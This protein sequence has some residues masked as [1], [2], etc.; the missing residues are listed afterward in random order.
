[1][2]L[3]IK[4]RT[5]IKLL[6]IG[7]GPEYQKINDLVFSNGLSEYIILTGKISHQEILSYYSIIDVFIYPRRKIRLTDLVTPLKPLEA[8][9]ME[10]IVIG[11]DVGG[12]KEL[13]LH[14]T[15][16]L[17]FEAGDIEDLMNKVLSVL[18][19]KK[20][21]ARL[22]KDARNT[23]ISERDSFSALIKSFTAS[24]LFDCLK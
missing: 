21:E 11:S 13:I 22:R 24:D 14:N 4:E 2:Q 19:N 3:L 8:M 12:L 5:D 16:G 20:C 6:M 7:D 10:K 1:M 23:V 9:A 17:I 15:N 18:V